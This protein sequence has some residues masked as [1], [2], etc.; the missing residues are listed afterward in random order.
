MNK[1]DVISAIQGMEFIHITL[2]K[3]LNLMGWIFI[4][5]GDEIQGMILI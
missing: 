4:L 1:Q 2:Q 3:I 5:Q